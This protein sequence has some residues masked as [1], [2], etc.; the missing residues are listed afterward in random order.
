MLP[1]EGHAY[2]ARESIMTVLA[3]QHDWLEKHVKNR[4][5]P[6]CA[7]Q[8]GGQAEIEAAMSKSVSNTRTDA[9]IDTVGDTIREKVLAAVG[10]E[11]VVKSK[12]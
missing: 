9:H 8:E 2:T 11:P 4:K 6:S 7:E 3:E 1:G 12:L 5:L 10:K